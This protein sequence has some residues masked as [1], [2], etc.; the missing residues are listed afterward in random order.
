M[1]V[2]F[3]DFSHSKVKVGGGDRQHRKLSE[4]KAK[5]VDELWEL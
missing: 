4:G 3:I 2:V 5:D 1:E